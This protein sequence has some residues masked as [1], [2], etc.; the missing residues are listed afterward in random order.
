[1]LQNIMTMVLV[2]LFKFSCI[3]RKQ[4]IWRRD[5]D[6]QRPERCSSI[7]NRVFHRFEKTFAPTEDLY[8]SKIIKH[9]FSTIHLSLVMRQENK[10]LFLTQWWSI[11]VSWFVSHLDKTLHCILRNNDKSEM[12]TQNMYKTLIYPKQFK[13]KKYT[14]VQWLYCLFNIL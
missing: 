1:M 9:G 13:L 6:Y 8:P 7:Q 10:L 14:L 4:G 2:L 5:D 3:R 12:L 11:C